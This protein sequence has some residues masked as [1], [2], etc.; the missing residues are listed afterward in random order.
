MHI[1]TSS[2]SSSPHKHR[3]GSHR[4]PL[5]CVACSPPF[6]PT[7]LPG[8]EQRSSALGPRQRP[9]TP[10]VCSLRPIPKWRASGVKRV[11]DR[12]ICNQAATPSSS[13]GFLLGT[14]ESINFTCLPRPARP[15]FFQ[16]TL[17]FQRP[18]CDLVFWCFV[19]MF[20]RKIDARWRRG[21]TAAFPPIEAA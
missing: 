4:S 18:N 16:R 9:H 8:A 3:S 17:N 19:H 11:V 2:S 21:Q 7:H 10:G 15:F 6:L 5:P 1:T 13:A 20:P 12:G 14:H